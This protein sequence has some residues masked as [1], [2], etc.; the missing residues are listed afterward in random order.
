M[1]TALDSNV[2]SSLW[3]AEASAPA[4]KKELV[5]ARAQGSIVM[6]AVVYV[7]LAAHPLVSSGRLDRLLAEADIT[8]EF[9][10]GE[11]VWRK[12]AERFAAYAQ[13]RRRSGGA[14]PKRLLADFIIAAH[15]IL[16]ADRLLTLDPLRYRRD[17]PELR[18][19]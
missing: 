13:R 10:L 4:V 12:T 19:A 5:N 18:L 2:L 8:V 17:F 6:C 7:E 1:K 11:A 15:A 3:S 9:D 14:S 16:E